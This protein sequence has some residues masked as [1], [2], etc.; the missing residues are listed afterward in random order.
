MFRFFTQ[1]FF[2]E[3]VGYLFKSLNSKLQKVNCGDAAA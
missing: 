2:R 3:L 1:I